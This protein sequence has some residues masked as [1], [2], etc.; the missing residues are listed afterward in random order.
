VRPLAAEL[1]WSEKPGEADETRE[2]RAAVMRYAAETESDDRLGAQARELAR[3]WAANRE[4][5]P[6]AVTRSVLDSAARR[7]DEATYSVLESTMLTAPELRDRAYLVDALAKVQDE[8]LRSRALG[9]A[10][11]P[12]FSG[13]DAFDLVEEALHDDHN[14]QAAFDF[15]RKNFD[16]LVKKLPQDTPGQLMT[17]LGDLCTPAERDAFVDFWKDR[18]GQFLGGPRRY[19]QALERIDICV[20]SRGGRA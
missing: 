10:L 2:L 14:R 20:A 15:V 13:R 7:T 6:A 12:D 3:K 4:A 8:K 11:R 19:R 16:A 9:L 5:V 17:P 18:A 1:G